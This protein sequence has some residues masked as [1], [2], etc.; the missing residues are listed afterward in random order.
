MPRFPGCEDKPSKAEREAC[1][2]EALLTFIYSNIKY[3]SIARENGLTGT[4]VASFVVEKDG[5]INNIE[6]IRDIGGGCGEE[7][8]RV[9]KLMNTMPERWIP[10]KQTGKSVR[11]Q[12]NLPVRFVLQ[13]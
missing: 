12:F 13:G 10:G 2:R 3:P 4:V 7:V 5:R 11:V 9:I 1:S 6:I 8:L